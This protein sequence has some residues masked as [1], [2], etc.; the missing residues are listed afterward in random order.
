[1]EIRG[2]A[3]TVAVNRSPRSFP[4]FIS[5]SPDL[6]RGY[7][8]RLAHNSIVCLFAGRLS[9]PAQQTNILRPRITLSLSP[10]TTLTGW[11]DGQMDGILRVAATEC[12]TYLVIH[13]SPR[14]FHDHVSCLAWRFWAPPKTVGGRAVASVACGYLISSLGQRAIGAGGRLVVCE[15]GVV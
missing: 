14:A 4:P 11:L 15:E 3:S 9:L 5:R 8:R 12:L 7:G 6:Q 10:S 1:V 13:R 2:P